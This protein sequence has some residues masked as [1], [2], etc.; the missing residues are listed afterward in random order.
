[1]KRIKGLIVVALVA[2]LS[3]ACERQD[4]NGAS[5]SVTFSSDMICK[6]NDPLKSSDP[7]PETS[8]INFKFD[9]DSLLTM[10]H[11]N[12]GFNCCPE[13]FAVDIEVKGDSLIIREDDIKHG[14]KCNCLFNLDMKVHNLPAGTY[15]VRIVETYVHYSWP[16]LIFDLDLKKVPEGEFCVTRPEGWWR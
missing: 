4:H 3:I 2:G 16:Q 12:A 8:C 11:Y 5:V 1:M 15:H 9:G 13:N 7:A 14:C 6:A 10:M